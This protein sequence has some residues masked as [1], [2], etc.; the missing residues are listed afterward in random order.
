MDGLAHLLSTGQGVVMERSPYSDVVFLE[1]LYRTKLISHEAY[2]GLL[3]V[4]YNSL[5]ELLM[6]HLI[7]YL[8]VPVDKTL[9]KFNSHFSEST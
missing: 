1:S 7:I 3:D 2:R 9:V 5:H 6:P 4:R 8:D